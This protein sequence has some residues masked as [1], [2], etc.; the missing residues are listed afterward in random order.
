MGFKLLPTNYNI[1]SKPPFWIVNKKTRKKLN[2][3]FHFI[4]LRNSNSNCETTASQLS[5]SSA[6]PIMNNKYLE[7]KKQSV[8]TLLMQ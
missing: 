6:T 2:F 7:F 5:E 1:T 8:S 3:L 4:D